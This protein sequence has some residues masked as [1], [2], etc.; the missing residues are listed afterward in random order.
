MRTFAVA[1]N[2]TIIESE[3]VMKIKPFILEALAYTLLTFPLAVVWHVLL[4]KSMYV[5][6]GY[7]GDE[8]SFL[9]GFIA[10]L[11]Q[12]ILLSYG[13]QIFYWGGKPWLQGLKYGAFTG[14]FLWS[15]H[16]IAFAAK[17]AISSLILFFIMESVYLSVQFALFGIVVGLVYGPVYRAD[18]I[19]ALC[20]LKRYHVFSWRSGHIPCVT[21][22]M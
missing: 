19:R 15:S 4:F 22:D 11:T 7:F 3:G 2:R 21:S 14:L 9:L 1:L 20:I 6:L 16:V 18:G 12:G 17:Q 10:I 8:P 13:F 5:S